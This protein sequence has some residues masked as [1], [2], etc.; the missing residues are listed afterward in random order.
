VRDITTD[1]SD[2]AVVRAIIAVAERLDL[3]VIAEG[4]ETEEQR[5]L[6]L[7]NGCIHFQ[8]YH[9][10]RPIPIEEFDATIKRH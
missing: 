6:L 4:V 5:Q 9:F 1:G 8:G 10:G 2:T 7:E 3:D